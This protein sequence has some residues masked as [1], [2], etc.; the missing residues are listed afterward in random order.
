MKQL[1]NKTKKLEMEIFLQAQIFCGV[2]L[3]FHSWWSELFIFA[4]SVLL[5]PKAK[6]AKSSSAKLKSMSLFYNKVCE[7][8]SLLGDL[9]DI[10]T[11]TDTDIL[12]VGFYF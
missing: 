12:Q 3:L 6:R 2:Y 9:V 5:I 7:L 8:V 11:L 1:I 4:E 10:Q